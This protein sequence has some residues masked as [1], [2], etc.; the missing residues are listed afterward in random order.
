MMTNKYCPRGEIK[1]LEVEMWNLKV[2]GTDVVG[3]NQRFQ[4]LALMCDKMFP[5]ESD[6]INKYVDGLSDMIHE[7]VMATK[8]KTMQ[9]VIKFATELMDKKICTLV[10]HQAEN[11]RKFKDTSRNN[12]N[13]QQP[14]I[15]HN[16]TWA[17]TVGH[18]EKK[19]YEGSKPLCPKCNYHHDRKCAPKCTNCKRIG[20]LAW[21]C[22]SSLLLPTTTREPKGQIKEFSLALS[23]E[24][25]ATSGKP[26]LQ[27]CHGYVPHKKR[28]ALI[29]FDIDTDRIF[30]ST[31]FSS[32]IDIVPITLDYGYD[33]ELDE[34]GSFDV[35]I[36][37]GWLSKY[38]AVIVCAE[39]IVR[40]PFGSEILFIHG[41]GSSH[42]YGS[43]LNIISC[44][45]THE[46]LL[47]GCPIFLALVTT[48]K[49]ED[50][51]EEQRLKDVLIVQDFLE[52][53][54]EDLPGIPPTRQVEFQIDL[55]NLVHGAAHVA[56]APYRLAPLK[57][58]EMSDQLKELF[59][60][61]F[62]RPRSEDFVVYCDASHKGLGAV[63]MQR[64]KV[65]AYASCQLKIYEKNYSTH[66]LEIGSVVFALKF[67][68]YY[69]YGTKCIVF[70]KSTT[71]PGSEGCAVDFYGVIRFR[72]RGKL[73]PRYIGPFKVL[74]KVGTVAYKLEL[75]QQLSRVHSTFHVFN[76]KKCLSDQPLAI[77]LDE[78]HIDDKLHF[79][80]EAVE[81]MDREVKRLKQSRILIIKVQ[82]NSRR[83]PEF[84]WERED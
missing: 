6:M 80:E 2:K 63:L 12:Q 26:K 38:Q 50:K 69:L 57:M 82:W 42:E 27:C 73:N 72:K 79:V 61:G 4:E 28:Y 51:S 49:A 68:R 35:I 59:D 19:P 48:K 23:V 20:H 5:E 46:Y 45:K 34:M 36:G 40:I 60:K 47:K 75:P 65:I 83:G 30:V 74:A 25:R 64:E 71:H 16:V 29:L 43:R 70:Q 53:F 15:R 41:D 76:L 58:K 44:T 17:Y 11:K 24:L 21:D 39:K 84:T 62:I 31:A 1:K 54:P 67:W 9:D 55:Y 22:K 56:W 66:D 10:V 8:P 14:F 37:M 3:Y 77:P 32:L 13:Q 33:V 7:S 78:I 18:G 52:V 81:I